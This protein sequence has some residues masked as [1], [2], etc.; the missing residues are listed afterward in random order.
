MNSAKVT[1][2]VPYGIGLGLC[3]PRCQYACADAPP[4]HVN[5]VVHSFRPEAP[6]EHCV[7]RVVVCHDTAMS[8]IRHDES[9]S[10]AEVVE[11]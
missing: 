3:F 8:P 5:C 6:L 9:F 1:A 4:K 2:G 10:L 7:R 11:P